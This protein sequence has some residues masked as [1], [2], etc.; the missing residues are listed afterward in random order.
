MVS[1]AAPW[2]DLELWENVSHFLM[3]DPVLV[4]AVLISINRH[5]WHL[6]EELVPLSLYDRR[7]SDDTT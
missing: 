3:S 5:L 6:S 4:E 1:S 2:L 7:T